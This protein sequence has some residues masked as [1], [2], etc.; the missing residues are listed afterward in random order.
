MKTQMRQK[1]KEFYEILDEEIEI[2][3]DDY[4]WKM[5]LILKVKI[6]KKRLFK[7]TSSI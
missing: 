2:T 3:E 4:S 5:L 7:E 1:H 6:Y